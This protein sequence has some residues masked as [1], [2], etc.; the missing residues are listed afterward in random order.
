MLAAID[1][2]S[3]QRKAGLDAPWKT[4]PDEVAQ[5]GLRPC[6]ERSRNPFV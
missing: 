4:I 2:E 6:C 1:G 5:A 3:G